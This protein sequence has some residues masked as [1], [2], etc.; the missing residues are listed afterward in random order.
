MQKQIL[1]VVLVTCWLTIYEFAFSGEN[2]SREPT[3]TCELSKRIEYGHPILLALSVKNNSSKTQTY[4]LDFPLF[5]FEIL[6][7]WNDGVDSE[8]KPNELY[9]LLTSAVHGRMSSI[10]SGEKLN[11][12]IDLQKYF[13]FSTPGKYKIRAK[14]N[15]I[16]Q[17][18]VTSDELEIVVG[19]A[20]PIEEIDFVRDPVGLAAKL[21]SPSDDDL[22]LTI[23]PE[24]KNVQHGNLAKLTITLANKSMKTILI[25]GAAATN[26]YLI[27]VANNEGDFGKDFVLNAASKT[28]LFEVFLS[29]SLDQDVVLKPKES[30]KLTVPLNLLYDM[31]MNWNYCIRVSLWIDLM[32]K[33]EAKKE[34]RSNIANICMYENEGELKNRRMLE[35]EIQ[36]IKVERERG[37][38]TI[39][40]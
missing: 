28:R 2:A 17:S 34:I 8:I 39:K 35:N 37:E 6:Y 30:L 27:D 23:M 40:E 21:E 13:D 36:R 4:G 32:N 20:P 18:K 22:S 15:F 26:K 31:S 16:N 14:M 33:S 38:R 1:Q 19:D 11:W 5:E 9:A 7:C 12:K 10:R 25:P 3:I 24:M 29:K